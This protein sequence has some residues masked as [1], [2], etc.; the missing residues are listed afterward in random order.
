MLWL[1][2]YP[3]LPLLEKNAWKVLTKWFLPRINEVKQSSISIITFTLSGLALGGL[4]R[5][6]VLVARLPTVIGLGF[7][8]KKKPNMRWGVEDMEFPGLF[9]KRHVEIPGFE[10]KWNFWRCSS[11][12]KMLILMHEFLTIEFP[13]GVIHFYRITR[14][15]M[16]FSLEFLRVKSHK[17]KNFRKEGGWKLYP[18]SSLLF[19]NSLATHLWL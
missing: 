14:G 2:S 7:S 5:V 13:I 10:L 4:K 15:E 9:N 3:T 16:W 19:W 18:Q 6:I 1:A 17:S 12:K 11:R 8:R